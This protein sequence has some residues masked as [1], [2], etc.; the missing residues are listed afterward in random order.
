MTL[1]TIGQGFDVHRFVP[2]DGVWLCGVKIPS[3]LEAA[4]PFRCG[5]GLASI[6]DAIFGAIAEGDIGVHFP[7]S[8]ERWRD[9]SSDQFLLHALELMRKRGGRLVHLD[10]TII[11]EKPQVGPHR[12]AMRARLA[13]LTGLPLSRISI[14]GKTTEGLGFTGRGEGLAAQAIAT[15]AFD[16][17]S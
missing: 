14:K 1:T 16:A 12:A 7:P 17:T 10:L 8:D 2:G 11:C 6:T 4:R 13:E 3:E 9:A 5:C 15:V